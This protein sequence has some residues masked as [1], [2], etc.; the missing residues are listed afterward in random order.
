MI[1]T[2]RKH[3]GW[4]WAIII[5]A[6]IASFIYWGTGNSHYNGR[7]GGGN[8]GSISGQKISRESYVGA[9]NEV[10]LG[11]FLRYGDW[12]DRA[13]RRTGFDEQ[14]QQQETY[15]RLM[16]IQEAE[17]MGISVGSAEVAREAQN[18][19]AQIGHMSH[20]NEPVPLG[21]FV[22]QI[23][24][25]HGLVME[26]FERFIRH[27]LE[28]HQLFTLVTVQGKLITPEE[29]RM[30]YVR[31][32]QELSTQAAFFDGSN[33]LAQISASP[34]TVAQFYTNQL[35]NY[36]LPDRVQVNYVEFPVSNY[37]AQ[38]ESDLVKSNLTELVE[39]NYERLGTNY[40]T[41]AKT[42][43]EAK[44]K[45]RV[46][47]IHLHALSLARKAANGFATTLFNQPSP[48]LE[49]MAELAHSRGLPLKLTEPFDRETGPK[50]SGLPLSLATSAFNLTPDDPFAAEPV[51]GESAVYVIALKK[52]LPSEIPPLEKIH[53][54][55]TA[56]CRYSQAVQL[57]K[58]ATT[59]FFN[60]ATN[61]MARGKSFSTACA[62]T[63][64]TP[65]L[66][67]PLSLSTQELPVVED[68]LTLNQYKE[69]AFSVPAGH[70]NFATT[71]EGGAVV[72]AESRLPMDE[73]KMKADMPAFIKAVQQQR[74]QEVFSQWL[75]SKEQVA[76]RDTP[77]A[78]PQSAGRAPAP[79]S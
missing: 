18:I 13:G 26:D 43:D 36:R 8:F 27:N 68:H 45:I 35:A 62:E 66:L 9:L 44:A 12:P 74:E 32:Y 22:S 21:A 76:L 48:T 19:L 39:A 73:A 69:I 40:Y 61:A 10:N 71:D 54:Q 60:T 38:A 30:L 56:D 70:V 78:H 77:L 1:G 49:S 28:I 58:E 11:F 59:N 79:A 20:A 42:P 72:Y 37:L 2:I 46:E 57:A 55:V 3:S 29:A 6:T 75:Y 34:A 4:L 17:K 23:L 41:D 52:Q 24:Q 5:V 47:L 7:E 31:R 16:L 33:Y 50:E 64:V 51:A 25:P 67:P 15:V 63:K 53:A 14:R 65:K